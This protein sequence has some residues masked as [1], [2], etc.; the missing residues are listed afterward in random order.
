MNKNRRS[1]NVVK[2]CF[3]LSELAILLREL[4]C[5]IPEDAMIAGGNINLDMVEFFAY[6]EKS[7]TC[8]I[9][10]GTL[11]INMFIPINQHIGKVREMK[12]MSKKYMESLNKSQ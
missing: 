11:P 1:K 8:P 5:D 10:H 9:P 6:T 2:Y 7:I 4:G 12:E 3:D